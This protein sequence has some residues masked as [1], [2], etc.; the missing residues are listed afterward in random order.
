MMIGGGG[1][2][3]DRAD[4]GIGV[5]SSKAAS[6]IA[7]AGRRDHDYGNEGFNLPDDGYALILW[8]R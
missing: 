1:Q 6:L 7:G 2:R 8:I 3:C 4:H 5:T